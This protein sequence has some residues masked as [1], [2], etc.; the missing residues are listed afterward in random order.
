[1]PLTILLTLLLQIFDWIV[2]T[3]LHVKERTVLLLNFLGLSTITRVFSLTF[4]VFWAIWND[5]RKT[6]THPKTKKFAIGILTCHVDGQGYVQN[7]F[8][9]CVA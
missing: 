4:W 7:H 9:G 8:F 3:P 2:C 6:E 5:K 1:M